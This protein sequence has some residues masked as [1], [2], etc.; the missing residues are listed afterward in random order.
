MLLKT[1]PAFG[2]L[3]TQV[4]NRIPFGSS[5]LK[6]GNGLVAVCAA[7]YSDDCE[8][9][10]NEQINRQMWTAV[11]VGAR[12]RPNDEMEKM[13]KERNM[14]FEKY[15]KE[16]EVLKE[17][18]KDML[19]VNDAGGGKSAS[20][21]MVLIDALERLGVSYLFEKEIEE[22]LEAMFKNFEDN[23]HVFHD[24][25]FMVSLHFRVFRQH[26]YNLSSSIFKKFTNGNGVFKETI[27]NDMMGMLSLYEATYLKVHGEDIL[28]EAFHFTKVGLESLKPHLSPRLGE[29]VAHALYQPLHRDIPRLQ[30]RY[31]ISFYENDPSRNE[32]VLRLAKIDFNRLQMLHKQELSHLIRWWK[33][34]DIRPHIPYARDRIVECFLSGVSNYF[35]PQYAFPRSIHSK[36]MILISA[37]DDT[38]DAYGT[39]EELKLFTNA[40][41]RWDDMD[42]ID[43][44]P[45]YMKGFYAAVQKFFGQLHEEMSKQDQTYAVRYLEEAG[46]SLMGQQQTQNTCNPHPHPRNNHHSQAT[47]NQVAT[48]LSP[49][50]QPQPPIDHEKSHQT[51]FLL[52]AQPIQSTSHKMAE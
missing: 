30:A 46:F 15:S 31:Y 16:V 1:A 38:Y 11:V 20:E 2:L 29:H 6:G 40:V 9:S 26:G 24:D 43:R 19:V 48:L 35:E 8:A 18:V 52:Q 22:N 28:D 49:D 36:S 32:K 50:E 27:C 12:V 42:A 47:R 25:L 17:E 33:D 41:Q 34:L 21:K 10:I 4:D 45:T 44:L 14:L 13:S 51:L 7:K 3:N 39:Y 5:Q 37:F 23:S